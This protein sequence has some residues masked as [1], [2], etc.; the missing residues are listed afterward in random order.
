MCKSIYS[1]RSCKQL[2]FEYH[3]FMCAGACDGVSC[4]STGARITNFGTRID[5]ILADV[6]LMGEGTGGVRMSECEIEG[7]EGAHHAGSDHCPVLAW[8]SLDACSALPSE[9][10]W[11]T[12]GR[13]LRQ[14]T[15][16][17]DTLQHQ[18]AINASCATHQT[19][20]ADRDPPPMCATFLP[21][22][23]LCA[24]MSVGERNTHREGGGGR[25]CLHTMACA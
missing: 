1:P 21:E 12:A 5:Y 16:C 19:P 13:G 15:T 20:A 18:H 9:S 14:N 25:E 3:V 8:L 22:V 2:R 7:H 23:L 17:E 4:I 24:C 10:W 6:C 11:A